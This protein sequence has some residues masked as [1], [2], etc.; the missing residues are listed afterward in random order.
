MSV[1]VRV[2]ILCMYQCCR[3]LGVKSEHNLVFFCGG[4]NEWNHC[5][6]V[7]NVATCTVEV[8]VLK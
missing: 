8:P 4:S 1:F 2:Y 7:R 6:H 3:M 5:T